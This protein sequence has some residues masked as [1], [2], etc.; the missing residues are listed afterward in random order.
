MIGVVLGSFY[1]DYTGLQACRGKKRE[2]A[3]TE[4]PFQAQRTSGLIFLQG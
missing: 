4:C 3:Q 1:F 2:N